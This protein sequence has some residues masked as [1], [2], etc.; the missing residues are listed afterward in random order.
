EPIVEGWVKSQ[1]GPAGAARIAAKNAREV[2]DR[3]KR[4]PQMMDKLEGYLDVQSH[5]PTPP[6]RERFAPWWGWFGLVLALSAIAF[7][8]LD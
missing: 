8:T 3:L 7:L 1:L 6:P 2:T 5:T 4:L